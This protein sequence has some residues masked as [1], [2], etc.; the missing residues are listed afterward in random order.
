LYIAR[1]GVFKKFLALG[2]QD[3]LHTIDT[4]KG[5]PTGAMFK[6]KACFRY[7]EYEKEAAIGANSGIEIIIKAG[8]EKKRGMDKIR[9]KMG[10]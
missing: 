5:K 10:Q 3:C 8:Q 7:Q 2:E 6:A 1:A 9:D 4:T